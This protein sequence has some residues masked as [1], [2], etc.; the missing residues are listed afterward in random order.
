MC[1]SALRL[2]G[3]G[4]RGLGQYRVVGGVAERPGDAPPV[5]RTRHRGPGLPPSTGPGHLTDCAIEDVAPA[6]RSG[7]ASAEGRVSQARDLF[8]LPELWR[9]VAS[10]LLLDWH[11]RL[12]MSD[13]RNMDEDVRRHIIIDLLCDLR[14]RRAADWRSGRSPSCAARRADLLLV[15]IPT[16]Q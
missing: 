15:R 10:G 16:S 14:L 2:S 4:G 9:A 8:D 11:A 6:L 3:R 12:L 7:P 13:L 5:G 1:R